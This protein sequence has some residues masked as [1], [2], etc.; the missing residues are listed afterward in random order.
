MATLPPIVDAHHHFYDPPANQFQS[1]LRSLG[2]PRWMPPQYTAAAA[3]VDLAASVHVEAMPDDGAAEAAWVEQLAAAGECRVKAIVGNCKLPRLSAAQELEALVAAAPSLLRGVRFILCH[4][5]PFDGGQN[6]T[7]VASTAPGHG[8]VDY[9]RDPHAAPMFERGFRLLALHNLSFD[10][11][12]C[13]AQLP[14]AA[15][16]FRRHAAV[17]VAINHLGKLRHLAA[18]GGEADAAKLAEWRRGMGMMAELRHVNVKISMLGYV[19]PGWTESAEK[20]DLLRQLVLETIQLFGAERCMFASN[21]HGS[22]A[23]GT[24]SISDGGPPC[25]MTILEL[26]QRYHSWVHHLSSY[27]QERLFSGTAK[28]FYRI[29]E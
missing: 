25:D 2:V 13:P 18:D 8:N 6:A 28:Q 12:C 16:L 29:D 5:G 3:G 15:E 24:I 26:Y 23:H 20:E 9:L 17:P 10:L 19:V 27:E 1:F 21:W 22:G 14:A 7:H 11:Q 4:D